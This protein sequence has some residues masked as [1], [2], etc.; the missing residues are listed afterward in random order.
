MVSCYGWETKKNLYKK[1][2]KGLSIAMYA[3]TERFSY[4]LRLTLCIFPQL[5]NVTVA[6]T[7]AS[8]LTL[9]QNEVVSFFFSFFTSNSQ[10]RFTMSW[11]I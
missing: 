1:K 2:K 9:L 10:A 8:S 5:I 3:R 6:Q 4:S 7:I 11:E